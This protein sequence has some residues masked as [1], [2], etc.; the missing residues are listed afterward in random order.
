M[1]F[2]EFDY[3]DPFKSI[4][5]YVCTAVI[6][7]C[8]LAVVFR[9]FFL[10]NE[11][12]NAVVTQFGKMVTVETAGFH[13][14]APWQSVKKVDMTTHGIGIGYSVDGEG[15]NITTNEDGVMI[16]KDFNLLNIDFYAEYR[17]TDPVA[18]LYNSSNPEEIFVNVAR[19]CIR[20]VVSNYTIDEAMTTSKNQIQADV[21]A[22]MIEELA[23]RNIGLSIINITVQDSEAPTEE[24]RNAFKAVEDA[25]QGASTSMNEALK[26]Q[27]SEIPAA[28]ANA[29]NIVQQAEATKNARIAEAQ[30]Q[31]KRFNEIYAQYAKFP[32][33][34]KKRLFYEMVEEVFPNVKIIITDG[35]TQTVYP[36]APFATGTTTTTTAPSKEQ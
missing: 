5:R 8:V 6:I 14:K 23:E 20:T 31:V 1:G 26:Y 34:T 10:V 12:Q 25:R 36:M 27:N 21:K 15:Q 11:Q 30:G 35:E 9:C 7:I 13:G 32:E 29:D 17:V 22:M 3:D 24:I 33:I 16:T 4:G 2:F 19:S 28:Q 18:Y